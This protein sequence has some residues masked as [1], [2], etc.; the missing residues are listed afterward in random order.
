MQFSTIAITIFSTFMATTYAL[1]AVEG[2][3]F[4]N[5]NERDEVMCGGKWCHPNCC[6]PG[7]LGHPA[8]VTCT[9]SC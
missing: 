8:S 7:I 3:D 6:L 4:N 2:V 5:L 1:P 9:T